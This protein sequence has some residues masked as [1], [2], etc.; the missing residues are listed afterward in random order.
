MQNGKCGSML[1][2]GPQ[3]GSQGRLGKDVGSLST[4]KGGSQAGVGMLNPPGPSHFAQLPCLGATG[5]H[6]EE[7]EQPSAQLG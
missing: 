1:Q 3:Q 7:G 4:K 5:E 2:D 6:T